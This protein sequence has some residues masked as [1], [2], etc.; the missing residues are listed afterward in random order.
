[1]PLS[2][3]QLKVPPEARGIPWR[4]WW[5]TCKVTG[6]AVPE[7]KPAPKPQPLKFGEVQR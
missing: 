4:E 6:D 5:R 1:M 2:A 3:I 7:P